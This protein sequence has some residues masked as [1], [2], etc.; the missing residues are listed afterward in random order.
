MIT[1]APV[2]ERL[3]AAM[4]TLTATPAYAG[5]LAR[6]GAVVMKV[7]VAGSEAVFARER[8]LWADAVRMTGATAD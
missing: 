4:A 8:T 3:R 7:P 1:T 5:E 6:R 2:L